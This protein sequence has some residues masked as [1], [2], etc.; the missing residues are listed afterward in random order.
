MYKI[1]KI[2]SHFEHE[3][4]V[5]EATRGESRGTSNNCVGEQKS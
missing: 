1:G 2:F 5:P 3:I 4:F